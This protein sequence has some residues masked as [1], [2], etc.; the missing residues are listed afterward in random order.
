M[1][2]KVPV[3]R[4]AAGEGEGAAAAGAKAAPHRMQNAASSGDSVAQAG[5]NFKG[6]SR[7]AACIAGKVPSSDGEVNPVLEHGVAGDVAK[8]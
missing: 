3:G 7:A 1:G 6:T 8:H 2:R 5:H 4:G